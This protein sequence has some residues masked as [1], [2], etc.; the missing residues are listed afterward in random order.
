MIVNGTR[1]TLI[2]NNTIKLEL[3]QI[4]EINLSLLHVKFADALNVK[5]KKNKMIMP[6]MLML[7]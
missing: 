2:H 5:K 7:T 4:I 3:I 6:S 1:T